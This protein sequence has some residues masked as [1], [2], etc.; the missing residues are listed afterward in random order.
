LRES[1]TQDRG[2]PIEIGII[3]AAALQ[4]SIIPLLNLALWQD[5][6]F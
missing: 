6:A 4:Y 5:D 1:K 2:L 3:G